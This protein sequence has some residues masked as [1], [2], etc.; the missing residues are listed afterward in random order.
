MLAL[1]RPRCSLTSIPLRQI[2]SIRSSPRKIPVYLRRQWT[3]T[4][5]RPPGT[6]RLPT[7]TD[8]SRYAASSDASRTEERIRLRDEKALSV[9]IKRLDS[10]QRRSIRNLVR[11]LHLADERT[12]PDFSLNTQLWKAYLAATRLT[13][14]IS[15]R[16]P[17]RAWDILWNAQHADPYNRKRRLPVLEHDLRSVGVTTAGQRVQYLQ[18]LFLKGE[19]EEALNS[20]ERDHN[21]SCNLLRHDYRPE[22]LEIGAKLHSLAGN[23]ERA[24]QLMEE[25]FN[26]YP[27][28]NASVMM[29]VFRAHTSSGLEENY[30]VAKDIYLKIRGQMGLDTTIETLDA[31]LVGFLEARSLRHAKQV[32]RDMCK[33]GYLDTSGNGRKVK[34][35]LK[36]LNQLYRLGTDIS[37]MTSIALDAISVLPVPFHGHVFSDWMK[38]A[39][40]EKAPE[41]AAQILDMMLQRGCAP[42]AFH[43]NMLLRALLR[44]GDTSKILQAENIGWRMVEKA[45]LEAITADRITDGAAQDIARKFNDRDVVNEKSQHVAPPEA[46]ITIAVP[47]ASITTFSI[48]MQHHAKSLQWEHVD[49]LARQ[50]REAGIA[51]NTSIMNVIIDSKCRQG[52]FGEAWMVYKSLTDNSDTQNNL[53]PDGK[54]IRSLW[55]VLRF[56]LSGNI[57]TTPESSNLPT[58]RA[59]L[60]ETVHWWKMCRG[61]YDAERFLQG[62]AGADHGAIMGLMMHCFSYTRD[63]PGCLV[64]L[65]V[66]RHK[67]DIFPNDKAFDIMKRQ[68]AWVD[69]RNESEAVRTQLALNK[70]N[71]RN[72]QSVENLFQHLLEQRMKRMNINSNQ[73]LNF[74]DE[75]LGD[76]SLNLLSEL[77]RAVMKRAYPPATIEAMINVAKDEVGV[78]D[79]ATGDLNA[80]Q[81][82]V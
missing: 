52:R 35:V 64:A 24:R 43:F 41:A 8:N 17:K 65:H 73:E 10:A 55:K 44:T 75:E 53:F 54:T 34:E 33:D 71:K 56:A 23:T 82:V 37:K 27:E 26:I 66:F 48:I 45:R 51:P 80:S 16:I 42:E 14:E 25:L 79:M 13:P 47:S 81:V 70:M 6:L 2:R 1:L 57:Q 62:L 49:Y 76:I 58:P 36:R 3:P 72:T 9:R 50:L 30:D 7:E 61:R 77:V 59:L 12:S 29:S 18:D 40:V 19:E 21:Q 22:H 69:M 63:L 5:Y 46:N 68:M 60:A 38:C 39:V 4:L 20:W 74:S 78:P 67:F 15:H 28:W 32:F 31:C 11:L